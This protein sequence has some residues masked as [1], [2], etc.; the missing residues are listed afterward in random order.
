MA[1]NFMNVHEKIFKEANVMQAEFGK[2]PVN[3]KQTTGACKRRIRKI[4]SDSQFRVAREC[5]VLVSYLKVHIEE[6]R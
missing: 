2:L 3:G 4:I 5:N 1:G 6:K